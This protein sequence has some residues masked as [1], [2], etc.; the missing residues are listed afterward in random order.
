VHDIVGADRV[1]QDILVTVFMLVFEHI[2]IDQAFDKIYRAQFLEQ[3]GIE[4][5]FVQAVFD[6][7]D[8]FGGFV[9][10]DRVY[11]NQQDI[12]ASGLIKK[13]PE[14]RVAHIAAVPV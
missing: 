13:R 9:A 11:V 1:E 4:R 3:C 6:S 7:G 2:V 12:T 10:A 14:G 5:D 8:V